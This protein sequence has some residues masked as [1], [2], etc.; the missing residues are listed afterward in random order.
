M[1]IITISRDSYSHGEE[2]AK[3][4]AE[5]LGY[6]CIGPAEIIQEACRH[7]GFPSSELKK[8]LHD[9]P[10]FPEKVSAKKEQF[11]AV[12]R[13]VFFEYM[14]RDH[15]VYHG[16]TGHIFLADVPNVLKVRIIADFED[17]IREQMEREDLTYGEAKKRLRLQDK[18]RSKWTRHLYGTDNHGPG[19]Y[20]IHLN[21]H[22]I[23]SREAVS[24]IA[25]SARVSTNGHEEIMRKRIRDMA[26][27]AKTEAHLFEI[28]PEVEAVAKDGVVFVSVNV[29][30][31]QEEKIADKA[32]ELVSGIEGIRRLNI[33]VVP[34]VYEPF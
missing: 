17:R 1:S 21:L 33:G 12:F 8:A 26:L 34:S 25:G 15:I 30:I 32:R 28:F 29:S 11:P 27:A 16:L 23:T 24:I 13:S 20:D 9:S 2:I 6:Q 7:M 22:N 5:T 19:R 31:L 14:C 3:A 10:T 4:V 18:E